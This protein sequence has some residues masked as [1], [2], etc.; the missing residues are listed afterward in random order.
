MKKRPLCPCNHC[1][2]ERKQSQ[3][4][5]HC[6]IYHQHCMIE[7]YISPMYWILDQHQYVFCIQPLY[8]I[9]SM[10][11]IYA[12]IWGILMVNVTIY[13]STMDPM[14]MIYHNTGII[15][16]H[17]TSCS[18]CSRLNPRRQIPCVL[19]RTRWWCPPSLM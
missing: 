9:G 16:H 17:T 8:P 1:S 7:F 2:N 19:R 14:G 15:Q 12:N 5:N 18:Q 13:S 6:I 11:G 4:I 3:Y 10:Y